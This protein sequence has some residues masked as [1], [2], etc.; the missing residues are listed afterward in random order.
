MAALFGLPY[1]AAAPDETLTGL[2]T[3]GNGD[4]GL[5]IIEVH[6]DA[7]HSWARHKALWRAAAKL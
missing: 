2:L 5:R 6:V 3:E 4:S 1:V 7:D